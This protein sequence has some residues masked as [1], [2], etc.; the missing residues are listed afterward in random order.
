VLYGIWGAAAMA[1]NGDAIQKLAAQFLALAEKQGAAL[2]L[3]VGHR[4]MGVSLLFTGNLIDARD[5]FDRSVTLYDPAQHPASAARFGQD[6]GAA[7]LAFRSL[8]QWLLGYGEGAAATAD[9]A[10]EIARNSGQVATLMY[11]LFFISPLHFLMGNYATAVAQA[12][13]LLA[14]A[15]EKLASFWIAGATL[16]QGC[17]LASTGR[18]GDAAQL[19][20]TGL[21]TSQVTGTTFW[22]PLYQSYLAKAHAELGSFVDAWRCIGEATRAVETTKETMFEAE[23][24]RIAGEIALK[25]PQP[26]GK[27]LS[28]EMTNNSENS[29]RHQ[30]QFKPGQSGNPAGKPEGTRN[31]ATLAVEALLDGEAEELTRKAIELAKGGDL[32][33]LRLCMDRL[34]PPRR[35]RPVIFALPPISSARDAAQTLSAVVTAVAAGEL[36]PADAGEISRLIEAYVKAFETAEL[37]ERLERLERMSNR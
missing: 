24:C 25:S 22:S 3:I 28:C 36:T 16:F 10:L 18:P 32:T 35:D 29:G 1:F 27:F 26:D 5:H 23:L 33:A 19:I 13:E 2:P 30:G 15:E 14:L 17:I 31:K 20:A 6:P 9:Q 12:Q 21:A 34:L 11:V 4:L 7:V 8:A 37:A